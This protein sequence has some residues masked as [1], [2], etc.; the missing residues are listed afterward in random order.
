LILFG[1]LSPSSKT[2]AVAWV[3]ADDVG[4]Q[5]ALLA[6]RVAHAAAHRQVVLD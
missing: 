6:Q 2:K 3:V 5:A 4:E 1:F